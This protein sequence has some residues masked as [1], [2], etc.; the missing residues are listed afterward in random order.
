MRFDLVTIFPEIF[1]SFLETSLVGKAVASGRLTFGFTDPR[2]F[3]ADRHRTVDDRPYGGGPGMVM[4]PDPLVAALESI[5]PASPGVPPHRVLLTPQGERLQQRHLADLAARPHVVL[6]C[7]RYEGVDERVRAHVHQEISLGDF[8]LGG[9]E[10]AAMAIIE[11]VARLVPGVIGS[12]G[13]LTSE[14]H[15]EPLLEYPQYTRPRAFR[16][17]EVPGV[18]LSGDH[19]RIEP[20]VL[21]ALH[22]SF[23]ALPR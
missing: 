16:G 3:A 5:G 13:S 14:S 11:G 2:D 7:G 15:Q 18:L 4:K 12:E 1:G 9:G 10:T 22:P 21:E 20:L 19:A 8:V 23:P 6:L 17:V